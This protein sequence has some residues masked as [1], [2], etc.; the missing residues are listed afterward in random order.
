MHGSGHSKGLE[1]LTLKLE[2]DVYSQL[3]KRNGYT[4]IGAMEDCSLDQL[5]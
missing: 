5:C 1:D 3:R 2:C 4:G